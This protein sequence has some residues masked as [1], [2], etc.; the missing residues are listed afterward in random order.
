MYTVPTNELLDRRVRR[1]GC[2]IGCLLMIWLIM[3]AAYVV[4][5]GFSTLLHTATDRYMVQQAQWNV[6]IGSPMQYIDA[7]LCA[8]LFLAVLVLS[9]WRPTRKIMR[10]LIIAVIAFSI[11]ILA[12]FPGGV[13]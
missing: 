7:G 6:Y 3:L 5:T 9:I 8:T 11:Y 1:R 10:G 12:T 2:N 4:A 13:L